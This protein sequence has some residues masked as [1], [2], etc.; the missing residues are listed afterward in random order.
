MK[1]L[2]I[3]EVARRVGIAPSTLRYY[4]RERLIPAAPRRGGRRV[5]GEEVL[6]RL[7]IVQM[8]KSAGFTLA[9]VRELL[10]GAS[11]ATRPG[12]RWRAFARTKRAELEAR[13]EEAE[14]MRAVLEALAS[15]RCRTFEECAEAART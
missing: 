2:D 13:I 7:T 8:A 5:Y 3:G 12:R 4:E 6:D 14:R 11:P 15:C 10:S 1:E 9:E